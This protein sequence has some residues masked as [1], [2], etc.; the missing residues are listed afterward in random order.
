LECFIYVILKH[1]FVCL[2]PNQKEGCDTTGL[3]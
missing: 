1:Y 3:T 2:I